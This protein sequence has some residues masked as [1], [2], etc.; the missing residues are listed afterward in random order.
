MLNHSIGMTGSSITGS[1]SSS[2]PENEETL[3]V[4]IKFRL[5]KNRFY[6]L[7]EHT[8]A[9][10]YGS[11]VSF[12]S[13]IS[14][15]ASIDGGANFQ[16]RARKVTVLFRTR[17]RPVTMIGSDDRVESRACPY[18]ARVSA[19]R[20][21]RPAPLP[22]LLCRRPARLSSPPRG[23]LSHT[24]AM[25]HDLRQS[26]PLTDKIPRRDTC[27][28]LLDFSPSSPSPFILLLYCLAVALVVVSA[29]RSARCGAS[30]R[31]ERV[32]GINVMPCQVADFIRDESYGRSRTISRCDDARAVACLIT[33]Q[34]VVDAC[35]RMSISSRG[36]EEIIIR[37]SLT[38]D[39]E[40]SHVAVIYDRYI[41]MTVVIAKSCPLQ[42]LDSSIVSVY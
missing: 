31:P 18:R 12:A 11:R 3:L 35:L 39:R 7:L 32:S 16:G 30:R 34:M 22:L 13:R 19:A 15:D 8:R 20:A 6:F 41:T 10:F 42:L 38:V 5:I 23:S 4:T 14:D 29:P 26:P 37:E 36:A 33:V 25:P 40:M 27:Y 1:S 2:S 24:R 17:C 9:S 28:F 21:C